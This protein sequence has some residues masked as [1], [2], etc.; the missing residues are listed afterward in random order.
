MRVLCC[1]IVEYRDGWKIKRM[2]I[3]KIYEKIT[4]YNAY[5][6]VCVTNNLYFVYTKIEM[7][8]DF[9]LCSYK[10]ILSNKRD[11]LNYVSD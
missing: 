5:F 3:Y 8:I 2:V 4:I 11:I 7:I 9:R 10:T 6:I 1:S